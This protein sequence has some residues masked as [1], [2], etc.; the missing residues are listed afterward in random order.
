MLWN[1]KGEVK[2]FGGG[3][4]SVPEDFWELCGQYAAGKCPAKSGVR[5]GAAYEKLQSSHGVD[6]F[7]CQREAWYRFP[8]G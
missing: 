4:G 5:I 8:T 1:G 6:S 7:D 3:R 2:L